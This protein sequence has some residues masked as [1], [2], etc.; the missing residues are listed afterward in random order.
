MNPIDK[1]KS[2]IVSPSASTLTLA[3][4][5]PL[6]LTWLLSLRP[7][8]LKIGDYYYNQGKFELSANGYQKFARQVRLR[9][10]QDKVD[11][12]KNVECLG[13]L[14]SSFLRLLPKVKT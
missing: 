8:R 2:G 1:K 11:D 6:T 13:I 4:I 9:V 14:N 10:D 7:I 5:L 12:S 3:L